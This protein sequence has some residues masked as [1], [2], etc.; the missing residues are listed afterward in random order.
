MRYD[1]PRLLDNDGISNA[2]I[3]LGDEILVVQRGVGDGGSGQ[4][5]RSHHRLR[6]QN[7]GPADLNDDVLHRRLLLLRRVFPRSGP[8]GKFCRLT[9]LFPA[10]QSVQLD[11]SPVNVKE[12]ALPVLPQRCNPFGDLLRCPQDRMFN[13]R[14]A[15]PG[16][17]V[18]RGA[19]RLKGR[20]VGELNIEDDAVQPP[21]GRNLGI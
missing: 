9:Q 19:V 2:D 15:Q 12:I 3:P 8:A 20:S 4:T 18:Q 16:Q 17:V 6:C 21:L 11:H 14:K 7:T 13:H 1:L 10:G 5:D